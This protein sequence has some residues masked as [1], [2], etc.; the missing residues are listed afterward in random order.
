VRVFTKVSSFLRLV[1]ILLPTTAGHSEEAMMYT[2]T[3]TATFPEEMANAIRETFSKPGMSWRNMS[4]PLE[5][6]IWQS[7]AFR[8]FA[9]HRD[10]YYIGG[11]YGEKDVLLWQGNTVTMTSTIPQSESDL[12]WLLGD[13]LEQCA[14]L[15]WTIGE[16]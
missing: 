5:M 8:R 11:C 3:F 12:E 14:S 13:M 1:F 2:I 7:M 16:E 15:N 9:N 10:S 6:N 4:L